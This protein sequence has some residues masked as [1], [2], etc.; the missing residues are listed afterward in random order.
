MKAEFIEYLK[1]VGLTGET[2]LNQAKD[3]WRI[4]ALLCPEDLKD[5]FVEEH[6]REDGTREWDSLEA[7]CDRYWVSAVGFL[8]ATP[9]YGITYIGKFVKAYTV[10][11]TEYDFNKATAKSRLNITV[12]FMDHSAMG[13]STL[14]A[15]G[16][17][18]DVLMKMIG[19]YLKANMIG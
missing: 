4:S 6:V 1:A 2:Q 9:R 19:K 16:D 10:Q 14:R 11:S 5:I 7:F 3:A 12:G 17:N 8:T 18:C 15:S 13:P